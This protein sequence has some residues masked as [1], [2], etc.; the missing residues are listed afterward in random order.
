MRIVETG[1]FAAGTACVFLIGI[2]LEKF[3]KPGMFLYGVLFPEPFQA[4]GA[5]PGKIKTQRAEISG[6]FSIGR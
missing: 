3:R 2:P 5:Y 6:M 1:P 4:V